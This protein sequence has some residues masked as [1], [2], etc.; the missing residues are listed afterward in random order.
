MQ[1]I[2]NI[3]F[4]FDDEKVR[5]TAEYAV[6]NEMTNIVKEVVMDKIAPKTSSAWNRNS[7]ERNWSNLWERVDSAIEKIVADNRDEIIEKAAAKLIR[8]AKSTKAW[9]EKFSEIVEEE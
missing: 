3:A 1:H 8:S 5:K 4:E 2:I 9:K 6:G 7:K